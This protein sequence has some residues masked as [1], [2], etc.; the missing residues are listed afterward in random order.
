MVADKLVVMD[1]EVAVLVS[2]AELEMDKPQT[3]VV[4]DKLVSGKFKA[5]HV[6]TVG[7]VPIGCQY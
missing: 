4:G 7:H 5:P 2:I 1:G 3:Q 6:A